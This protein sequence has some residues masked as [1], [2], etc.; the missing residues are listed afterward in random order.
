[1]SSSVPRNRLR[2]FWVRVRRY[3]CVCY[4][5]LQTTA[6]LL[7]LSSVHGAGL[8]QLNSTKYFHYAVNHLWIAECIITKPMTSYYWENLI[9]SLTF[10]FL[11]TIF[12]LICMELKVNYC[13]FK[14]EVTSLCSTPVFQNKQRGGRLACL[15]VLCGK[16]WHLDMWLS[17]SGGKPAGLQRAKC[18]MQGW[19]RA[20]LA[21]CVVVFCHEGAFQT[22]NWK[23]DSDVNARG[24]SSLWQ[25]VTHV[26]VR[27]QILWKTGKDFWWS[28]LN[29]WWR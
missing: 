19:Q 7:C 25:C 4:Q 11:Y 24:R 28:R 6:V 20:T 23:S 27:G 14:S 2:S 16:S 21:E 29:V 1:M 12:L 26:W 17:R 9:K 8:F 15:P 13:L 3:F 18:Q 5:T 22:V 10:L